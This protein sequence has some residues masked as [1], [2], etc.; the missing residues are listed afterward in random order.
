MASRNIILR[1]VPEAARAAL[2]RYA[3]MVNLPLEEAAIELI[4]VGLRV[5]RWAGGPT[6]PR[7]PLDTLLGEVIHPG[8]LTKQQLEEWEDSV[9]RATKERFQPWA[10]PSGAEPTDGTVS[11]TDLPTLGYHDVAELLEI[12][13]KEKAG[14]RKARAT[15]GKLDKLFAGD[16][17]FDPNAVLVHSPQLAQ[18]A[19]EIIAS[20]PQRIYPVGDEEPPLPAPNGPT[21]PAHDYEIPPQVAQT[22]EETDA[23]LHAAI[24]RGPPKPA[25]A[26]PVASGLLF[27]LLA[28][29]D[30]P[31]A[32]R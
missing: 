26:S 22:V 30:A 7:D 23:A 31:G 12:K 3:T 29:Q 24:R 13:A 11:E 28:A 15:S 16:E 9:Q 5:P 27:A 14:A 2:Q 20:E 21:R 10:T 18:V 4:V 8:A 17:N 25:P 19:Q 32:R 6:P 1:K